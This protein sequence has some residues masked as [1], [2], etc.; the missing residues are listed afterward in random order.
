[1]LIACICDGPD[2]SDFRTRRRAPRA[3]SPSAGLM[4]CFQPLRRPW[5]AAGEAT[6]LIRSVSLAPRPGS[7]LSRWAG[8][9]ICDRSSDAAR[10]SAGLE[11]R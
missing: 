8:G 1:M 2:Y 5:A 4:A 10:L 3:V 6:H 11:R 7:A 9:G